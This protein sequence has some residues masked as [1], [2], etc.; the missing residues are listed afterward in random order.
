MYLYS[1]IA[2]VLLGFIMET[3]LVR[4][5]APVLSLRVTVFIYIFLQEILALLLHCMALLVSLSFA[6]VVQTGNVLN[7]NSALLI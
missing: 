7:R 5:C 6:I 3:S 4:H 2:A 1:T